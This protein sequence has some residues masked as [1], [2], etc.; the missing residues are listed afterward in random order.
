MMRGA[1]VVVL[2]AAMATTAQ[3]GERGYELRH[4]DAKRPAPLVVIL[5]CYGCPPSYL[6]QHLGVDAAAKRYGFVVAVPAGLSDSRGQPFWNA[7]PACCDFDGKKPDDAGYVMRVIDEL[8]QR[9][10]ADPKRVYLVGF[11]N[12]GF[13]AYRLACEQAAKI[14]A[15]VSIGGAAPETCNPSAPVSV[16]EVHGQRD[17]IV[18]PDGGKLGGGFPQRAAFPS[19][20]AT[21]ASPP[22]PSAGAAATARSNAGPYPAA[23]RP[24]SPASSSTACGGGSPRNTSSAPGKRSARQAAQ[25]IGVHSSTRLPSR[26]RT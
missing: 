22:A 5:H 25:P 23:M 14:A 18:P 16:L 24:T 7:T 19:A 20:R 4:A 3:A 2:A 15:I 13:L 26:S 11:S 17:E 9:G 10:T 12:G 21:V 8:V 1:A 6:P